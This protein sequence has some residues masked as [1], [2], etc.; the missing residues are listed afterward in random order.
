MGTPSGPGPGYGG[1]QQ[2][3]Q[4]QQ[5]YGQMPPQMQGQMPGG[6]MYG[7]GQQAGPPPSNFMGQAVLAIFCC[8]PF[9]IPALINSSQVQS[10]WMMGDQAGAHAASREAKKWANIAIWLGVAWLVIVILFYVLA[11]AFGLSILN[12]SGRL[13]INGTPVTP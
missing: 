2:P 10:K 11:I 6:G 1:G 8:W 13:V 4:P 12:F 7:G 3:Q 9:A 5:P